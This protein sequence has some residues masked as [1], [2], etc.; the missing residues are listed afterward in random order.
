MQYT[1]TGLNP[2]GKYGP[3]GEMQRKS[4]AFV[5]ALTPRVSS[6]AINVG[7]KYAANPG[8]VGIQS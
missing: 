1:L 2:E 5:G 3:T 6:V 4:F 8:S 7:L